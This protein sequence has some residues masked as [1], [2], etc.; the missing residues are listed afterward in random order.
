MNTSSFKK[1]CLAPC[2]AALA[3]IA[4]VGL[5]TA[6]N[7]TNANLR[8]SLIPFKQV[9]AVY[10]GSSG[11]F[12]AE[13]NSDGTITFQL[14][15]A[16]MSSPVAQAHIHFGQTTANGGIM[17]F[18][19]GGAKPACPATGT[20]TGALTAAD[21][22]TLPATNGDSVI[23]QGIQPGN[24]AAM[25]AAIRS[26]NAYVNVHTANFPSGEIRGQ[27]NLY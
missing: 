17:A 16:N 26:G 13:I 23:P 3:F 24:L 8:A 15:Y 14:S 6:Q 18:L 2:L 19:C 12:Q 22:S 7:A 5:A 4:T 10:A 21:V 20:V 27:V 9:P 1:R 11:S 25:L